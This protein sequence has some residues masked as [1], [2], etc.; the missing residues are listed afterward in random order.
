MSKHQR[1]LIHQQKQK[2]GVQ[3]YLNYLW[4]DNLHYHPHLLSTIVILSL[5]LSKISPSYSIFCLPLCSLNFLYVI[6]LPCHEPLYPS[7]FQYWF[8][9]FTP[10]VIL[11]FHK[12]TSILPFFF[13]MCMCNVRHFSFSFINLFVFQ[14]NKIDILSP[15]LTL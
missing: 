15:I 8:S 1:K 9:S 13:A 7:F 5:S 2:N 12:M 6:V 3:I 11:S 10:S 14:S 4:N